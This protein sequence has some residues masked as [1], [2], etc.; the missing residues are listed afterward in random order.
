VR[1]R[2][3]EERSERGSKVDSRR[4]PSSGIRASGA[5]DFSERLD[6]QAALPR[7]VEEHLARYRY[8]SRFVAGMRVLDVATG[9]GFGAQFLLEAGARGVVGVEIDAEAV[10]VAARMQ[11]RGLAFVRA[12]ALRLPF[13]EATFDACVASETIEHVSDGKKFLDEVARVVTVDG[14]LVL[15]TPN[16]LSNQIS[17]D[18]PFHVRE[19][20]PDELTALVSERFEVIRIGGQFPARRGPRRWVRRWLASSG[21]AHRLRSLLPRTMRTLGS[22]VVSGDA[23]VVET[24]ELARLDPA[25]V[26]I[27]AR[28]R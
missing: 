18:N 1:K 4:W 22:Q 26:A 6:A 3:G 5:G 19:Y 9:T 10:A 13:A 2:H 11:L 14:I 28:R 24:T 21:I 27:V 23:A 20:E 15:T 16:L 7:L 8:A 25:T 12:D 17:H